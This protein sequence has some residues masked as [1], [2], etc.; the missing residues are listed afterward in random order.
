MCRAVGRTDLGRLSSIAVTKIVPAGSWFIVE[1]LPA[2]HFFNITSG[3]AKIFKQLS[4]GRRLITGFAGRGAFLGLATANAYSFTAE[5]L[6]EVRF[7]RYERPKLKA[8]LSDLPAM[9]HHLLDM[10]SDELVAAQE[11]ML[12]LGRKNACERLASFLIRLVAML[13]PGAPDAAADGEVVDL[14]MTRSDIADYLGLTIE[15]VSRSF[16]HLRR[17]QM[18]ET[19]T[20]TRVVIRNRGDLYTMA[21]G[22]QA[23][24]RHDDDRQSANHAIKSKT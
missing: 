8:M 19:P 14:P 3:T 6:D 18:I 16:T 24:A 17:A 1:G 13:P 7:C 15:T 23:P 22:G 4:D 10:A 11:Q 2:T 12:L 5:A 20:A 21:G 9:E